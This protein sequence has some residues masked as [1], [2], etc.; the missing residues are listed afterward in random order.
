MGIGRNF[1]SELSK[2]MTLRVIKD[3][4]NLKKYAGDLLVVWDIYGSEDSKTIT[5]SYENDPRFKDYRWS[6]GKSFFDEH[7]TIVDKVQESINF[8]RGRDPKE[9]MGIGLGPDIHTTVDNC[10]IQI[11]PKNKM[12]WIYFD[13]DGWDDSVSAVHQI[14]AFA[15]GDHDLIDYEELEDVLGQY[16]Y[17]YVGGDTWN[18]DGFEVSLPIKRI[19]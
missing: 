6:M 2:G 15:K 19:K 10:D 16:G 12:A 17:E 3:I 14:S 13:P 7:L 8:E 4:P 11:S 1:F 5:Y 18:S 9:A